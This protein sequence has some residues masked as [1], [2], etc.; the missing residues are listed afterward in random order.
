MPK[1]GTT[2]AMRGFSMVEM[3]VALVFTLILMAGMATVFKTSLTT[4]YTSSEKLST[5]R[6]NRSAVDLLADDLNNAGMYLTDLSVPPAVTTT[7]PAFYIS[8]NPVDLSGIGVTQGADQLFF[9]MDEPLAFEGR[10]V[11]VG[12]GIVAN[13]SADEAVNTATA[14]DA[15]LDS[16][17]IIECVDESYAKLVQPGLTFILKDSWQ[18]FHIVT[19]TRAGS[20]VTIVVG[21]DPD[22][23]VLGRGAIDVPAKAKH[24]NEAGVVFITP[25]QMVRYSVVGRRLDPANPTQDVPCLVRDQGTYSGNGFVATAT[26]QIITENVSGFRVLLSADSGR[27]WTGGGANWAAIRAALDTQLSTV[28]RTDHTTT[29]GNDHWFRSIPILVRVNVTTRTATQRTEYSTTAT[30][31]LAYNEQTQ[32]LV[33]IPRHFGL[34]MN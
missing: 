24:I 19:A 25:S 8:P 12:T 1:Q 7:N 22:A 3:L 32:S 30:P 34:A 29:Q 14:M 10:L 23:A 4:F 27:T 20:R 13:R 21:A 18:S 33:M 11:T 15:S 17:Y 5:A 28:G 2:P 6:R 31:A 9:Y 26:Q 16:T